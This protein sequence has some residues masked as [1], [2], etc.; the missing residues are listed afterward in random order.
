M[1]RFEPGY[2]CGGQRGGR[3]SILK[4]KRG[5]A[6]PRMRPCM[7]FQ[8]GGLLSFNKAQEVLGSLVSPVH[9]SRYPHPKSQTL[10]PG[11]LAP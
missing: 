11:L 3:G 6:P 9:P 10:T 4:K 5:Q 8:R 7:V 1:L 2:G